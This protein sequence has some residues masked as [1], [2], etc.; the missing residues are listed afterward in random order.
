MG[1]SCY[2]STSLFDPLETC[3]IFLPD[4]DRL[5]LGQWWIIE[6][7]MNAGFESVVEC[8]NPV[9]SEEEN[10]LIILENAQENYSRSVLGV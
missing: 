9:G 5:H 10:S 1:L 4:L 6:T 7:N 8:A 3:K 2:L